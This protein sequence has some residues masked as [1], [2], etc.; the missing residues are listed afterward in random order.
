L[1]ARPVH[2]IALEFLS[3]TIADLL[4]EGPRRGRKI[5]THEHRKEPFRAQAWKK[6]CL[7]ERC[8]AEPRLA[9][10]QD[11][12]FITREPRQSLDLAIA[13]VEKGLPRLRKR[14]ESRPRMLDVQGG[15]V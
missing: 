5:Q 15:P 12:R 9:V 13:A 1:R 14:V 10:Q 8:L 11:E 2:P 6:A 7:Q 4:G 3:D